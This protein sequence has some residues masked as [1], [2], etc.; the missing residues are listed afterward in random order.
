MM[1]KEA[2]SK[3]NFERSVEIFE[4]TALEMGWKIPTVHD[5]QE[6]MKNF[7]KDVAQMKVFE[8]CHPEHAY[9]ILSRDKERIVSNMMPCRVSIYEKS[10][11][12]TYI[13]WMNTSMMGNMMGGVIADV[14]GVAS[15]ESEKMISAIKK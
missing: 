12:N 11:G 9:E 2:E 8:L 4:Q 13:S 6:T 10:D 3:Y 7:G 15:A 1:L 14:M 5:M